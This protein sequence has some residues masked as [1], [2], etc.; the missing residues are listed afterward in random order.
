MKTVKVKIAVV[1]DTDGKWSAAGWSIEPDV[2][3]RLAY[4]IDAIDTASEVF[5]TEEDE[6]AKYWITAE[7]EVPEEKKP[8]EIEG[9]VIKSE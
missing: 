9:K 8:V 5:D 2:I 4:E 7:L 1:V 6:L 3:Q